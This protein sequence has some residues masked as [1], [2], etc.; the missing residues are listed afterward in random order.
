M[1]PQTPTTPI[2]PRWNADLIARYDLS[3]PRY[4]SYP[5]APQFHD[6]IG[7]DD[8]AEALVRGNRAA[9]PLSLYF[10]IPFCSTVCYYCGCNKIITANR[11]RAAPYLERLISEMTLYGQQLDQT[12]VVEQLHWGGGTPTYISDAEKERLMSATARLF[13][14]RGDDRGEYSIEIHPGETTLSSLDCLRS[15]GFNRLSM[16]IQDF[17]PGVQRA[18]N[19]FNSVGQVRAL[20]ERA[21]SL[22]FHSLGFD[23]IYGLPRQTRASFVK[24]LEAVIELSPDRLS[25]FNYAHMP[26]LFKTQRQIDARE[27]P[28]PGEKLGMLHDSIDRLLEAGYV[29]IGMDHFARPDDALARAQREGRLQR[30]F[31]GY[32]THGHC[33]LVA[34]GVSAIS[35]IDDLYVQNCKNLAE[36]QQAL[37]AGRLPL[38]RGLRRSEDDRIRAAVIGELICHFELVFAAIERRFGISFDRYFASELAQLEPMVSDGLVELDATGIRVT[39]VERLLIRSICMIFDAYVGKGSSQPRYSRI[40]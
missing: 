6:G 38:S 34:M 8:V 14:L 21:R 15:L 10:H 30:N 26:E 9:R 17:D 37:D 28:E 12:R 4:T 2:S 29:Y 5:T 27:L 16:G 13:N 3:G 1:A 31:Q 39:P 25:V 19:R 18:V 35:A 24:T 36:Y 7:A 23:L 20:V 11:K 22:G 40:I 32:A 33:D